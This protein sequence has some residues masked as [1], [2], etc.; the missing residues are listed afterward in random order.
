MENKSILF[1]IFYLICLVSSIRD[2]DYVKWPFESYKFSWLHNLT[3]MDSNW[4]IATKDPSE[5]INDQPNIQ[6]LL[7]TMFKRRDSHHSYLEG[8]TFTFWIILMFIIFFQILAF[9]FFVIG[10]LTNKP[11][12]CATL[13]RKKYKCF[14]IWKV[15]FFLLFLC[16]GGYFLFVGLTATSKYYHALDSQC[17]EIKP[18]FE[19]IDKFKSDIFVGTNAIPKTIDRL[20]TTLAELNEEV[21]S[22]N[23]R[24]DVTD[25]FK[26]F[27]NTCENLRKDIKNAGKGNHEWE[28]STEFAKYQPTVI[29][30]I[31]FFGIIL[32][33]TIFLIYLFRILTA[34][35]INHFFNFMIG[36][37]R[38]LLWISIGVTFFLLGTGFTVFADVC[39]N[40]KPVMLTIA[41][42]TDLKYEVFEVPFE[43]KSIAEYYINCPKNTNLPLFDDVRFKMNEKIEKLKSKKEALD[44]A[45]EN[46]ITETQEGHLRP[47]KRNFDYHYQILITSF[48]DHLTDTE[49]LTNCKYLRQK[50]QPF[51]RALLIGDELCKVHTE[52]GAKIIWM[53]IFLL[54]CDW[55]L[56]FL[57]LFSACC[58]I[59]LKEK[60]TTKKNREDTIIPKRHGTKYDESL[61]IELSSSNSVVEPGVCYPEA[62]T[63]SWDCLQQEGLVVSNKHHFTAPDGYYPETDNHCSVVALVVEKEEDKENQYNEN[64]ET[65]MKK[66]VFI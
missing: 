62:E 21:R 24:I 5:L 18:L 2:D 17:D 58:T 45:Y 22:T 7:L 53:L 63:E 51:G 9:M 65:G 47:N 55:A 60:K 59:K 3:R 34:L 48:K 64:M 28:M 40:S 46:E 19:N 39:A 26:D 11:C 1:L 27:Q 49:R 8:A 41:A 56:I 37:I 43:L 30:Y 33:V 50:N 35:D 23:V 4:L 12:T 57:A 61:Q 16:Y 31:W 10:C 29:L 66:T 38:A 36:G 54:S 20:L 14:K 32:F 13:S 15:C 44:E 52:I 25:T 42:K 6:K